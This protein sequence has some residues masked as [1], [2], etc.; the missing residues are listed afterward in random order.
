[1][2]DALLLC[3]EVAERKSTVLKR[4]KLEPKNY[5]LATVHRAEN[6]DEKDK[7]KNILDSLSEI[8]KKRPV[9]FPIHPRTKKAL[10]TYQMLPSPSDRLQIIDPVSYFDMLLLEKNACKILTDSGGIQ[11]EAYI[12]QVP[13][14]TLRDE[15]EWVETVE[16]GLNILSGQNS[17]KIIAAALKESPPP[18]KHESLQSVYGD[19][20]TAERIIKFL[21]G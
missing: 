18:H 9:I 16:S 4:L 8:S 3:L 11:K 19:G 13:C 10:E 12:L 1:M 7:L 5:F 2:Y 21:I 6:T 17:E 20:K 15:T 14:V